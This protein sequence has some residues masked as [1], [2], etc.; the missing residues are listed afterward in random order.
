M[1][2]KIIF[3]DIDGTLVDHHGVMPES[4][5]EAIKKAR[6]NGHLIFLCTGRSKVKVVGDATKLEVDGKVYSAGGYIEVHD[7]IIREEFIPVATVKHIV[8]FLDAHNINFCLE[9]PDKT[10]ISRN[11]RQFFTAVKEKSMAANP[12]KKEQIEAHLQG[13]INHMV[14][15]E[16]LIREDICKVIFV[17]STVPYETL[18]EEFKDEM[19]ILPSSMGFWGSNSGEMM[20]PNVHKASGIE[21]VLKHLGFKKEDTMA[22]GDSFN[23]MEMLEFVQTGVAMGNAC[24][25]LKE[26][27]D[28]ITDS[29]EED[30]LYN[31][32]KAHGLLE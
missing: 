29:V 20:I 13:L 25:A 30:G 15:G 14:D 12:E 26:I 16:N 32:F 2:K 27:A 1:N 21:L 28:E 3:C 23:D 31:S 4:T 5:K 10:Y 11:A 17:A 8:E 19:V 24:D 6:A 18:R 9:A 22:Y 7:K